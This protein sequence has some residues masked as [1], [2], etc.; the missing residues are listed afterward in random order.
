MRRLSTA[1]ISMSCSHFDEPL[2]TSAVR[3]LLFTLTSAPFVNPWKRSI[4]D[5]LPSTGPVV[6]FISTEAHTAEGRSWTVVWGQRNNSSA[7][8]SELHC[9]CFSSA[10]SLSPV[11]KAARASQAALRAECWMMLM[12]LLSWGQNYFGQAERC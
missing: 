2:L 1:P 6:P 5:V 12:D 7:H 10:A 4:G 8:E 9:V 11:R 3:S